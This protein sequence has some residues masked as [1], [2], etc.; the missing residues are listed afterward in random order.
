MHQADWAKTNSVNLCLRR[1]LKWVPFSMAM[2]VSGPGI[3]L[4]RNAL[5]SYIHQD[6]SRHIKTYQDISRHI[7]TY[8]NISRHIKTYQDISRH[9]K[10]YQDISRHIKT[11][12]DISRHI[13]T[14]Q[15]ISRHIKTYQDISRHIKTYQAPKRVYTLLWYSFIFDSL[16][17]QFQYLSVKLDSCYILLLLE[18]SQISLPMWLGPKWLARGT[19]SGLHTFRGLHHHW[20]NEGR[21]MGSWKGIWNLGTIQLQPLAGKQLLDFVAKTHS[22]CF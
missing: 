22:V 5:R 12:Q 15:D 3:Q 18:V 16:A 19:F 4:F 11:Y 7:K 21:E 10:T 20:P 1:T 13:K 14:Y 8:Q 2:L 9:I 17:A 6:I